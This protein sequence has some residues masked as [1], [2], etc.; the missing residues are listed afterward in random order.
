MALREEILN[1]APGYAQSD[2]TSEQTAA[3][4][5]PREVSD[6][7]RR[8]FSAITS[9]QLSETQL[10]RIATPSATYPDQASVLAV[11]WH[12]EH[13]PLELAM[14]RLLATFPNAESR[15]II[16]TQHNQLLALEGLAGVEVDAFASGFK[17]KVQLLLHFRESDLKRAHTLSQML[18]HTFRYRSSQLQEYM[19]SILDPRWRERVQKAAAETGANQDLVEF[20][21]LMVAKLKCL[22]EEMGDK[23]P[24]TMIKNRLVNDFLAA[25]REHYPERLVARA[26]IFAGAVK[27]IV[28][29]EFAL[30]YFYR[31]SEVI[32]E[33]RALGGG[34]VIP[35]PEQFWPIL[36]AD[37]DVDGYEV[38]N[39]QSQ[40]FTE[41]LIQ[42]V[43]RQNRSWRPGRRDLLVFM[44]DDTH[45]SE[46]A[47]DTARQ[48]P[49]KSAR[50]VGLQPPWDDPAL[51]KSLRRVGLNRDR[52]IKEYRL[53]L[54]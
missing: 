27:A 16:P 54:G 30:D 10:Q 20:V 1:S 40:E 37:Y 31:A 48:D 42:V 18:D 33:A 2:D 39:P 23:T 21:Q 25:Q 49:Q 24:P 46:K 5:D 51:R 38:W 29:K 15:L 50:E 12:P 13:I 47:K 8:V 44:G 22:M 41:F 14:H 17:R 3:L 7:D 11:H 45:L 26:R 4:C 6:W 43:V 53:R 35:H 36:L 52:V 9:T 28:K 34:V 19:D 32:E